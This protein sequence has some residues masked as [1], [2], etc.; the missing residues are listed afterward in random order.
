MKATKPN[1]MT[2]RRPAIS[3]QEAREVAA[4]I[5]GDDGDRDH[6]IVKLSLRVPE[7]VRRTLKLI[8]VK[9]GTEVQALILEALRDKHPEA[10]EDRQP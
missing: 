3:K 2:I 6:R 9:R 4:A 8:A 10:W 7:S 1:P 5:V